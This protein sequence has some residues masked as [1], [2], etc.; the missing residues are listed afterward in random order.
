M[1]GTTIAQAIPI[2][3]SPILTRIY[4]PADFGVVA[5]YVAISSIFGSIANASYEQAILLPKKDEDAINIFALGFIITSIM[6]LVLFIFILLFNKY[7]TDFIGNEEIGFWLYFVP[8]TVFFI[9]IF[10]ILN[11]FNNR[12]KN[13]RDIANVTIMKSIILSIIQISMGFAKQGA[14]GLITGQLISNFFGN[15]KLFKNILKNR[16]L[17]SKISKEKIIMVAI[18]YKRFPQFS[19]PST[20]LDTISLHI[21]ILLLGVFFNTAI[22]GL[23][24]LSNKLVRIPTQAIG[25]SISQVFYQ[26]LTEVK[27]NQ[28]AIKKLTLKTYKKLV[29]IGIVPFSIII[30]FGDYIFYFLFSEEWIVAGEYAQILSLWILVV[31]IFSPLSSLCFIFDKQKEDMYFTFT[32]LFAKIIAILLGVFVLKSAYY[33]IILLS[34]TG[35]FF[36]TLWSMYLLR[37]SSLNIFK[38]L[39]F[40]IKYIILCVGSL[41]LV[42]IY[43]C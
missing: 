20:M 31:F 42:R 30:V 41:L 37:L 39:F 21:P 6:S 38:T 25:S 28:E 36:W 34:I 1:T 33:T 13:Y 19:M 35:L 4:T 22:V 15:I 29:Q 8:I 17:L 3:I 16:F 11:Y 2:A 14:T 43:L 23:Y 32:T 10:N 26:Q 40:T 5:L 12:K 27:N 24:S 7:I 9:G 18:K